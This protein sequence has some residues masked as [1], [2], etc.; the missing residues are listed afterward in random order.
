MKGTWS[1][2]FLSHSSTMFYQ[3]LSNLSIFFTVKN[4]MQ[5]VEKDTCEVN[6]ILS[7]EPY[8]HVRGIVQEMGLYY[9]DVMHEHQ[10]ISL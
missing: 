5:L 2:L 10:V 1:A 7:Y 3:G 4:I 9:K 6:P 8:P